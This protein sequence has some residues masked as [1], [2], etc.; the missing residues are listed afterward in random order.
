M[1][2]DDGFFSRWSRRKAQAQRGGAPAADAAPQ[3][4]AQAPAFAKPVAAPAAAPAAAVAAPAATM[5][6]APAE[7]A[8]P[9]PTLDDVARLTPDADFSRFVARG[10]DEGVKRAAMKKL[11]SDPRFNVMDGLDVY[12]DDYNVTTPIP[13]AELRQLAQA[14]AL[15]L[16]DDE[17]EKQEPQRAAADAAVAAPRGPEVAPDGAPAAPLSQSVSAAPAAAHADTPPIA[18]EDPDLRLQPHDAARRPG[19]DAGAGRERG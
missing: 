17:E 7:P 1:S 2:D 6:P 11:F 14:R 16:F 4:A 12:I 5:P 19:P 8:A 3:A 15:G 9:L 10:V 13:P 18:D